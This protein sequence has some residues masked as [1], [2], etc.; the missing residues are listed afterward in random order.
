M[1]RALIVVD[2]QNDF[3]R[4]DGALSVPGGTYTYF[5]RVHTF[6]RGSFRVKG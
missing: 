1:A 2:Y 6:M 5:C 3:A 4:P